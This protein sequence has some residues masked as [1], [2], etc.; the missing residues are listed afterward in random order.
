MPGKALADWL[1]E[2]G[3]S[4]AV[5]STVLALARAAVSVSGEIQ[6]GSGSIAPSDRNVDRPGGGDEPMT[7]QRCG[8]E[9]FVE[10]VSG[11]P[12]ALYASGD[13]EHPEV[14]DPTAPLAVAVDSVDGAGNVDINMPIGTVFAMLPVVGDAVGD[15]LKS[16]L[17]PGVNQVASGFFCYGP[18]LVM[19]ITLGRGTHV[20]VYA[21]RVGAF[22]RSHVAVQIPDKTDEFAVDFSNQRHWDGAVRHYVD[23]CIRG[24]EGPH[25]RDCTMRWTE[26]VVADAYRIL[27]RGGV[28]LHPGD[29]G[30]GYTQG[31]LQLVYQANPI[32]FLVEQAGGRATDGVT[33]LLSQVP[34]SLHQSTPL[35]FGS[36]T[37]VAQV[38]RYHDEVDH[39]GIHS[40]LFTSR[41]LFRI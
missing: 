20:F 1:D 37:E 27:I 31:R 6:S 25:G 30:G 9:R 21:P 22:I 34:H 19:A 33:Q 4:H 2:A 11:A 15:P 35:V 26:S 7:L 29:S 24:A 23:D 3:G 41:G 14:F 12:V 17:Q 32:A 28:F 38:A 10:E 40:P 16:L 18:R 8:D 36:S 13:R 5:R 39:A